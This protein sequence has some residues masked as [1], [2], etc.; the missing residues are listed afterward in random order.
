[1]DFLYFLLPLFVL[2]LALMFYA[3]R[4]VILTFIGQDQF[5]IVI[6]FAVT[7]FTLSILGLLLALLKLVLFLVL[8]LIAV[9]AF[10]GFIFYVFKKLHDHKDK[11][12]EK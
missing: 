10:L 2:V 4:K 12:N 3:Q 1:M 11:E 8:W 6:T 9:L 7:L 5:Q